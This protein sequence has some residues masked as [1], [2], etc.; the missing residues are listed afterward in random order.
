[1]FP[2]LADAETAGFFPPTFLPALVIS[3]I[4]ALVSLLLFVAF[5]R[6]IDWL[7]PGDLNSEILGTEAKELNGV[8]IPAKTPNIALAIVVGALALGFCIIIA[9]AIH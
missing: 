9:A 7:T 6:F 2:L 4:F 1:M 5:W 8:V 3:V